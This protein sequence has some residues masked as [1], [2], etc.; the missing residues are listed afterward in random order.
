MP[1]PPVCASCSQ[2][3]AWIPHLPRGQPC[4]CRASSAAPARGPAWGPAP[5]HGV[6]ILPQEAGVH[7]TLAELQLRAGVIVH[8]VDAHLLQDPE[9]ALREGRAPIRTWDLR[10]SADRAGHARVQRVL[11]DQNAGCSGVH[12]PRRESQT[13][14]QS[15]GSCVS[16]ATR[17]SQRTTVGRGERGTSVP[18]L[19]M[20]KQSPGEATGQGLSGQSFSTLA[21]EGPP[22][23]PVGARRQGRQGRPPLTPQT[24]HCPPDI[25]RTRL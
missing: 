7:R 20:Q 1:L 6:E 2:P 25:S 18:I 23:H 13:P 10:S 21:E 22:R 3:L 19:W 15:A 4:L 11:R 5:V 24:Q 8:V 9:A 16:G 17:V 14:N 12:L